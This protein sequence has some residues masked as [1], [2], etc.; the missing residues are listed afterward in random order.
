MSD[1]YAYRFPP[2]LD[3]YYNAF[4]FDSEDE[5]V[6]QIPIKLSEYEDSSA[7]LPYEV[8]VKIKNIRKKNEKDIDCPI[9]NNNV[10]SI[11]R[12]EFEEV[13]YYQ[14]QVRYDA[15]KANV[16][17][18]SCQEWSSIC[19]TKCVDGIS[20]DVSVTYSYPNLVIAGTLNTTE[21][22][23]NEYL[24]KAVLTAFNSSWKP[25]AIENIPIQI[26][27]N[28]FTYETPYQNS[29]SSNTNFEIFAVTNNGYEVVNFK[30]DIAGDSPTSPTSSPTKIVTKAAPGENRISFSYTQNSS[31]KNNFFL[32]RKDLFNNNQKIVTTF[33]ESGNF[34]V[35]LIDRDTELGK[36]YEY[37]FKQ[38]GFIETL[39]SNEPVCDNYH[40]VCLIGVY[41]DQTVK[42][43]LPYNTSLNSITLGLSDSIIETLGS[44]YPFVNR[45]ANLNYKK[46]QLSSLISI[47][48]DIDE[49]FFTQQKVQ[50][51]DSYSTVVNTDNGK[52]YK[53]LIG[54]NLQD[55]PYYSY[56]DD[57]FI[58]EKLFRDKIVDFLSNGQPKV[59]KSLTDGNML[60]KLTDISLSGNPQIGNKVY[61]LS[62]TVTEV[63][64]VSKAI[65]YGINLVESRKQEE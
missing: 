11:P 42:L 32:I 7:S 37:Y 54:G 30:S 16:N 65:K 44:K 38:D 29:W 2:I 18:T 22:S 55:E 33:S 43:N 8:K 12:K 21:N 1:S 39:I 52:I 48:S 4:Q 20:F 14:I 45:N 23:L 9:V 13:G 3:S 51:H 56:I 40:G 50:Y 57:S 34:S 63:G 46:F 27:Q 41:N 61:T 17:T 19:S 53:R 5:S 28:S 35:D 64:E 58:N 25:I 49:Y 59:L 15:T 31:V 36:S 10:V 6:I 26:G 62:A 24:Y 60:V 47:N